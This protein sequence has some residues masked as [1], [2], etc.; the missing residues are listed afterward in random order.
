VYGPADVLQPREISQPSI[1]DDEVLVQVRAAGVD[2]GAWQGPRPAQG[3]HC[4][5][6]AR[7]GD[8]AAANAVS[9]L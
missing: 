6:F 8:F 1:G 4:L 2:P 5:L 9:L 3:A 7:C